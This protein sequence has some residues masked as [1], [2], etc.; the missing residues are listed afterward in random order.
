MAI[1]GTEKAAGM[2]KGHVKM[3]VP[4]GSEKNSKTPAQ[5]IGRVWKES[6]EHF[7]GSQEGRI[8]R[9]HKGALIFYFVHFHIASI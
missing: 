5:S 2:L 8:G 9:G 1:P 4:R 6:L 7:H 3:S